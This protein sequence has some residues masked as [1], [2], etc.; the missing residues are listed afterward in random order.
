MARLGEGGW[1]SKHP[2][3]PRLLLPFRA[4]AS[5]EGATAPK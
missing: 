2:L 4:P 1:A 5:S 3:F